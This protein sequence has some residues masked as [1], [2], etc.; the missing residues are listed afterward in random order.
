M[1][2]YRLPGPVTGQPGWPKEIKGDTRFRIEVKGRKR[3]S[4]GADEPLIVALERAGMVL[5]SSCRAGE[6]GLC[7]TKLISGRVFQ[8][9]EEK[10]RKSDR[11]FGFIHA[12]QAYPLED[13]QVMI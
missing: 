1:E 11:V 13:L 2:A 6:C 3:I 8:P 10:L 4:G 12:C 9:R 7:R 5:P